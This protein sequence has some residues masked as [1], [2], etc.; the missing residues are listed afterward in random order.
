M[1]AKAL[2]KK[3]IGIAKIRTAGVIAGVE[4]VT[5]KH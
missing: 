5:Q 4:K 2:T 1:L 3:L